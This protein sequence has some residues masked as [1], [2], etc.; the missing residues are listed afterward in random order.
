VID[1]GITANQDLKDPA[2]PNPSAS[3][4][5]YSQSFIPHA[6]TG[7]DQ[8]GHGTHV[9]GILAGNGSASTGANYTRTFAGLA[10]HA[11]LINLRVLDGNGQG[12]D[13]AVIAAIG[14]AI[15]LKNTYNIRVINL[16]LGGPA[17]Q[18]YQDDPMCEAVER[19]VHAGIVVVAARTGWES[20][21]RIY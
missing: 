21:T 20:A 11:N 16:S 15:E 12:N 9:A 4:I 3:R 7:Q 2:N 10:R 5:V 14:R 1:S 17:E 19:A 13:S 8:Y 6:P 18:S